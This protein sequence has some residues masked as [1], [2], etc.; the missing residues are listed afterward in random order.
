M[1]RHFI[2]SLILYTI[3]KSQ[4]YHNIFESVSTGDY[5]VMSVLSNTYHRHDSEDENELR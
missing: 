5:D 1:L 4:E 2:R 3:P